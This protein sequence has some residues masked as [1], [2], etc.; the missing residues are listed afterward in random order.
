MQETR[1]GM[2][3]V[4]SGPSG[5]GKG[6]LLTR[7]LKED[8]SFTFSVSATTRA[9]RE[10]EV[11]G[12]HYHFLTNEQFDQLVAENAFVEYASVH[13]NRYG[14]LKS[15]VDERMEKGQN[16]LLDIDTQG[17][18]HVMEEMPW[19]VSL[20]ILPPS[21]KALRE[22]LAGR[23]TETEEQIERRFQNARKEIP[24]MD[25]YQYII[26]NDDLDAAYAQLRA[27]TIAEK[28]RSSRYFP[29]VPEE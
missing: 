18:L 2:L 24:L 7:L 27:V 6:T 21:Y 8:E 22:R 17:A 1:K 11:D 3:L 20:F 23:G 5:T 4:I 9:P 25:H 16:V 13:G 28:Q 12:V 14:T 10:G 26:V 15:E 29:A 19:C